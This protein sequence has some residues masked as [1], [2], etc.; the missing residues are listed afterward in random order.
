MKNRICQLV[1]VLLL[2]LAHRAIAQVG[3]NG[4]YSQNFDSM[5]P[6]GTVPPTGWSFFGALGGGNATWTNV[7]G[8]PA[9]SVGG[10]TL[11]NT[12]TATTAFTTSSNT[13]G[14]NFALP[15][16]TGD[17][18]IGTSPTS[19]Q[20]LVLQ[21]AL[22]NSTG[23]AISAIR[24][25]YDIRRFTAPAANQLPGY[26]LFYSV[27]GGTT[28]Q[29]AG[30][31]NPTLTGP[32]GVIV[33]STTGVTTVP[34]TAV[35]L[36]SPWTAGTQLLL[37]WVDDNA[38]ETSPDQIL[39]LDNVVI[40]IPVGQPPTVAI[41]SPAG[42]STFAVGSTINF[43]AS[44]ADTDGTIAKVEFFEGANKLG[45][46][47]SAP[48]ELAWTG[49]AAGT[50][51]ITA[52]ATDNSGN[53]T[54][55][56]PI[57]VTANAGPSG[58]LTRGPYLNQAN[59]NSIVIRWRSSLPIIGRVRYGTTSG[60]L[61]QSVD[62]T[63]PTTEHIVQLTGLDAYTRYYYSVGSALDTLA[64]GDAGH[65]FRTSPAP[66][67]ATDTRIW[68]LGDAGRANSSQAAVR[69]AYYTW[70]GTR[71][72]DLCLM[73]GDNAYNSGTDAEYQAAVFDMYPTFLRKMPLWSC[74]GNHDANNGSTSSTAKASRF[75]RIRISSWRPR[76]SPL[77]RPSSP[78]AQ[79]T[80][81]W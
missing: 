58:T 31:L 5:G 76:S 57:A 21:L 73:L 16:S 72:P 71:T 74:I 47:A 69:D 65:S 9:A 32:A 34:A 56:A 70:T 66:G 24:I 28:W 48:Y 64:G 63:A 46:D 51:G 41:T 15:A 39:G 54:S 60:S 17:R 37:R 20:G 25:R 43:A 14:Y 53:T 18:A 4:S 29:N 26:G 36:A 1:A 75:P 49:F 19:G 33:P 2:L 13:A 68:V 10:G 81:R 80:P 42:G 61:T 7:T 27:N 62:E 40:D 38:A 50:Y 6:T 59:Q 35:S 22:S 11:N 12:L 8:I 44:A 77:R 55:S 30:A 23:S 3:F 45:E 52:R 78:E 67:T 79:T